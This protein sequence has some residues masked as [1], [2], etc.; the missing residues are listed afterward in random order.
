ML[1]LSVSAERKLMRSKVSECTELECGGDSGQKNCI[2]RCV[3]EECYNEIYLDEPLEE[4]E[5][6]TRREKLFTKCFYARR[7]SGL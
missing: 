4:G 2:N 3:S 5:I 7:R 1:A 6:D